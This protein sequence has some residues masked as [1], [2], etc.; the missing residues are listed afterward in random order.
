MFPPLLSE[1]YK[2]NFLH[3]LYHELLD[4]CDEV[5][6]SLAVTEDQAVNLENETQG[7]AKSKL[8]FQHRA[9]RITASHFKAAACTDATQPSQSL[10]KSICYPEAYKFNSAATWYIHVYEILY[11]LIVW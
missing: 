2:T 3:L 1:L 6:D 7:Q 5:F 11:V 8:W 9:G 4:Q 10:I